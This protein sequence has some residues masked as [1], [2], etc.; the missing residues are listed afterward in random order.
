MVTQLMQYV[1]IFTG[2]LRYIAGDAYG[3][4]DVETGGGL[5]G[6]W[7]HAFRPVIMLATPSGPGASNDRAHFSIDPEY[8]TWVNHYLQKHFGIQYIGNWHDHHELGMDHPSSGDVD[9][10]HGVAS[11]HNIPRMVQI[12]ITREEHVHSSQNVFGSRTTNGTHMRINT[13]I[14]P[15]A[16]QGPYERCGLKTLPDQSPIRRALAESDIIQ[17]PGR[18]HYDSLPLN[19]I[20]YDE[21]DSYDEHPP[22]QTIP[23]SLLQQIDCLPDQITDHIEV[24]AN[25]GLFIVTIPLSTQKRLCIAYQA[26]MSR[27]CVHSVYVINARTEKSQDITKQAI[28]N[29]YYMPLSQIINRVT[30]LGWQ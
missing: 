11:R 10:I 26:N 18:P 17:V 19:R 16:A 3:W 12:V 8:V 28:P 29:D 5:Y 21:V 4:R 25:S 7:T 1:T 14:Y 23:T 22:E 13:F 30:Q 2:C 6:L 15:D 27:P 24:F 9:Q 20:L